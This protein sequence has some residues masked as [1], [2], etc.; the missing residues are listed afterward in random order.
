MSKEKILIVA[1]AHGMMVNS[2]INHLQDADYITHLADGNIKNI[3]HIKDSFNAVFIFADDNLVVDH[4]VQ[5]YLRD[6]CVEEDMPLFLIGEQSELEEIANNIHK[7]SITKEF[8]RPVNI[9]EVAAEVDE[10]MQDHS[11]KNKKKIL[12]VDDSGPM[13]RSVKSWLGDR[14]QVILAN[15]GTMAIKYLTLNRPDL[16]LLDYEMPVVDGSQVLGMI[17]SEKEFADIPVIFLTSKNDR[18]S[19][20]NVVGLKPEGYLLKTM[21]PQE[22]VRHI[23]DFF[24]MQKSKMLM[25]N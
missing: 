25:Q 15:S 24:E 7:N 22:I 13:L 10:F 20:Q 14:Y 4:Q 9:A 16:V 11:K 18:E 17:R 23:D 12:V 5:I 8:L 6:R 19:V 3:N 2:F 1:N 21:K